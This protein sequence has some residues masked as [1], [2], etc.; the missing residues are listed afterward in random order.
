MSDPAEPRVDDRAA[1]LT[2]PGPERG[3]DV[4]APC[5]QCG[6]DMFAVRG[7]RHAVCPNCGFKDSC[8]Y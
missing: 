6:E 3:S 5:P 4:M 1:A 7:S 2:P 8:C